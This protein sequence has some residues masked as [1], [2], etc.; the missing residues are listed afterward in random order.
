LSWGGASAP[1]LLK[2]I[3]MQG[4]YG[5]LIIVIAYGMGQGILEDYFLWLDTTPFTL[6]SG[7]RLTL[8]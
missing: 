8:L 4:A 3:I 6:L 7:E 5:G 2:G 1:L